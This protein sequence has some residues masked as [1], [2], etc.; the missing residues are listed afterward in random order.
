[1]LS[2]Y[3]PTAGVVFGR[4]FV[5]P[6]LLRQHNLLQLLPFY[7]LLSLPLAWRQHGISLPVCVCRESIYYL[8][9]RR[10]VT[11]TSGGFTYLM[12]LMY[13]WRRRREGR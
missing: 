3:Y 4:L 10:G 7:Q 11:S 9:R 13:R 12:L 2:G 6:C 8:Q 1:M 5:T